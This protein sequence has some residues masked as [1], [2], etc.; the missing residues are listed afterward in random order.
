[1]RPLTATQLTQHLIDTADAL[2]ASVP[3][4]VL[5]LISMTLVLK[6]ASD[7][8][9][10][11]NVPEWMHWQQITE[12]PETAEPGRRLYVVM[13]E[14]GASNP[15]VLE[16]VFESLDFPT[17]LRRAE[18]ETLISSFSQVSLSNENLEFTDTVGDAYDRFLE[19]TT[20]KTSRRGNEPYTSRPFVELMVRLVKPE[21]GQSVYDPF[22]GIA[23]MLIGASQYV[24]E[25]YGDE[26]RIYGEDLNRSHWAAAK[27]NLLLHGVPTNQLV[28]GDSLN[29][30][31]LTTIDGTVMRFDRVLAR[32][33]LATSYKRKQVR[34]PERM[35][36]GWA[37]EHG[38]ADLMYVQHALASLGL[39]GL[40]AV[41]ASQGVLFRSGAE[42]Q[43]RGGIVMDGRIKAVISLGANVFPGTSIPVCIL[44]L[45]GVGIHDDTIKFIDA[46]QEMVTGRTPRRLEP[47]TTEKIIDVLDNPQ[48]LPGFSRTVT[49][50]EIAD[51]EFNL[52]VRRYVEAG[53]S[54]QSQPDARAILFGGVPRREVEEQADRFRTFGIDPA[55][56][57]QIRDANYLDFP[58]GGYEAIVARI[59]DLT[60]AREKEFSTQCKV[61]WAAT[62]SDIADLATANRLLRSRSELMASFRTQLS[63]MGILDVYQLSG[64]FAA[65]WTDWHASLRTLDQSG[66]RAV[67]SRWNE[68]TTDRLDRLPES[69]VREQVFV[70]L[71][72]DLCDR[73]RA[74][75]AG[76]R[77]K[78]A[79]VYRSWGERYA[80]SLASLEAEQE[81]AVARLRSR[82]LD[83]GY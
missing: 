66:F 2:L 78:L 5:G 77:Q 52:S 42:E 55:V 69:R 72:V 70:R 80:T 73:T 75:V 35:Q 63:L 19:R 68:V 64:A 65:W 38:R 74:L 15:D 8:P 24:G 29:N 58:P 25:Q 40:G 44:V 34:Y 41:V 39:G 54:T 81:A 50:E 51:N 26:V 27:L 49:L 56:L 12:I 20:G 7:Q 37:P 36:Y 33:P 17:E 48:D 53:P 60:A 32:P 3:T 18:V 59:P 30:P 62:T 83:L 14:S 1:M 28:P 9:G 22:A 82:L 47:E 6:R 31:R 67:F 61:W 79:D 46:E 45:N 10:T 43:I 13:K 16:G 4:A 23:G 76:E 21:P 57:F 71:G 11:L